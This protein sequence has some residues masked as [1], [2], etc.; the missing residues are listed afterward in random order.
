MG[1]D[2]DY[3]KKLFIRFLKENNCYKEFFKN[4]YNVN[5]NRQFKEFNDLLS[6]S[7]YHKRSEII[8]AFDWIHTSYGVIKWAEL[9]KK[10]EELL[11]GNTYY[12]Q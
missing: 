5:C 10:W 4:F 2:F 12:T 7:Y 8:N 1:N 3:R 9:N 6:Y 11:Y